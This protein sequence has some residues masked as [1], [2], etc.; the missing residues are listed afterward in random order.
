MKA[1]ITSTARWAW[2]VVNPVWRLAFPAWRAWRRR[3]PSLYEGTE[4]A[5]RSSAFSLI[6]AQNRW[7]ST[8]SV[9]GTGSTMA[10][11]A[12][13]RAALPP[14]LQKL[15][16]KRFLDAPCGDFNWMPHVR[17]PE[18][19]RYIG[20]DIVPDIVAKLAER[21]GTEKRSFMRLDIVEDALPEADLWL[22]RDVL[23]HLSNADVASVL[24]NMA[25]STI[26]WFLISTYDI[27]AENQDII[28]GGFRFLD[29]HKAPFNLPAPQQRIDDFVFP[30]PPRTLGL[31]S[32]EQIAA[33]VGTRAA[34][35]AR[36]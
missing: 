36:G 19:C 28:S 31:W 16:V 29:L 2:P 32:R 30:Y 5:D 20:A 13:L 24:R 6:H 25:R 35:R 22:C 33:A 8:E 17:L 14:L 26:R 10:Y 21:H 12:P 11:T 15:G 9:S 34:E 23:I 4:Y 7:G 18:D 27:G 3:P 1:A